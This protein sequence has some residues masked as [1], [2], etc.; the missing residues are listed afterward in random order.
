MQHLKIAYNDSYRMLHGLP[1][2]T[3]ARELQIEDDIVTFDALLRKSMFRIIDGCQKSDNLLIRYTVK[4][5]YF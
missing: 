1:R 5:D 2:N 4:S 3:S